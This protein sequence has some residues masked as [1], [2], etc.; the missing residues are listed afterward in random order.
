MTDQLGQTSHSLQLTDSSHRSPSRT[1]VSSSF[2]FDTSFDQTLAI[3]RLTSVRQL[4]S[5]AKLNMSVDTTPLSTF[6]SI[7]SMSTSTQVPPLCHLLDFGLCRQFLSHG[8]R[9]PERSHVSGFRGT[10]RYA[11]IRAHMKRDQQLI[12]DIWSWFFS[13]C[14]LLFGCLPWDHCANRDAVAQHKLRL[15]T[16]SI[17]SGQRLVDSIVVDCAALHCLRSARSAPVQNDQLTESARQ[18]AALLCPTHVHR[19][20]ISI[21]ELLLP[22][23]RALFDATQPPVPFNEPPPYAQIAEQLWHC[24]ASDR[25]LFVAPLTIP[26]SP[27]Q[28][29]P[30]PTPSSSSTPQPPNQHPQ[31]PHR[32]SNVEDNSLTSPPTSSPAVS[33]PRPPPT[34]PSGSV[35]RFRRSRV[36]Q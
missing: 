29:S 25:D 20:L 3:N 32:P 27:K 19:C 33:R 7:N 28:R 36:V 6:V 4:K 18:L 30:S 2:D 13:L 22:F 1:S 5:C 8:Q 14:E 17:T 26:D 12:D 21:A 24:F 31:S 16:Q 11:S 10:P 15:W 23:D 35:S 34:S 9:L